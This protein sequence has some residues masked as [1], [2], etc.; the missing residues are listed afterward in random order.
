VIIKHLPDNF[1]DWLFFHAEVVYFAARKDDP[2][3]LGD[4]VSGDF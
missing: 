1:F 3:S 2:T 4:L